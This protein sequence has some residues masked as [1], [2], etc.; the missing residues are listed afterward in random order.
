MTRILLILILL[1]SS[2]FSP[3]PVFAGKAVSSP[4]IAAEIARRQVKVDKIMAGLDASTDL[5]EITNKRTQI[6]ELQTSTQTELD[7]LEGELGQLTSVLVDISSRSEG[8]VSQ[9]PPAAVSG[10][11]QQ[12]K[13]AGADIDLHQKKLILEQQVGNY[14]LLLLS[15]ENALKT[16]EIARKKR[17]SHNLVY[18]GDDIGSVAMGVTAKF[19]VEKWRTYFSWPKRVTSQELDILTPN[20]FDLLPALLVLLLEF[21]RGLPK[22]RS[23]LMSFVEKDNLFYYLDRFLLCKSLFFNLF[24]G[25][26]AGAVLVSYI[27]P[28]ANFIS[29]AACWLCIFLFYWTAAPLCVRAVLYRLVISKTG[30]SEKIRPEQIALFWFFFSFFTALDVLT[31]SNIPGFIFDLQLLILWRFCVLFFSL[32]FLV[33]TLRSLRHN[34]PDS[35]I[36]R[37]LWL[38]I[39]LSSIVLIVMEGLGYRNLVTW[40]FRGM[41]QTMVLFAFVLFINDGI[42]LFSAVTS[43]Y[44]SRIL[45]VLFHDEKENVLPVENADGNSGALVKFG[46]KLLL[47][48]SFPWL[49]STIWDGAAEE[50][51]QFQLLF[52]EG[53]HI[54]N[55]LVSPLRLMVAVLTMLIGWSLIHYLRRI[56][57]KFWLRQSNISN[58]SRDTMLTLSGYLA[59][60]ALILVSLSIAGFKLTGLSMVLGALSVGIGFGLQNVVN[61][62]I[63][64]LIL[65]FEQPIK[66][67]DW[68]KAGSTEGTVK[69]ISIR[70]TIIQ[71]FDYADVI[72]PNSELI[73]SSVTN[74]MFLDSR[75]RVKTFV[76]VAYGSD[77]RLVEKLLYEAA[78]ACNLV[79][80]KEEWHAM[81]P[82]V[83]FAE[84]GDS[85]LN[86]DLHCYLRNIGDIREVQSFLHFE[87]DNLFRK[88]NI[89]IPFPQSDVHIRN[90]SPV[91]V[92]VKKEDIEQ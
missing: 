40:L 49:I 67:G 66:K 65:M 31:F 74:M 41:W 16:L 6:L 21:L 63:S 36:C 13:G 37:I 58:N 53:F 88:N 15:C 4:S 52:T 14:K 24:V 33:L 20:F 1:L 51:N 25:L 42:D 72:V 17:A 83:Y 79:I 73:S 39:L 54:G 26:F 62:F 48:L 71:T 70:S 60:G 43:K 57:D 82:R 90:N 38:L 61:N 85:S 23:F 84:F 27:N 35:I 12:K 75:G 50:S 76:G 46:L 55:L 86:F 30:E 28:S 47:Y 3:P 77:V 69:K 68:V 87:I 64:G 5:E 32:L 45:D 19:D 92:K 8:V 18:K 59:I 2:S 91:E 34:Y 9:L 22:L 80:R 78:A 44:S 10:S 29:I 56:L 7:A 89:E 81:R 11:S